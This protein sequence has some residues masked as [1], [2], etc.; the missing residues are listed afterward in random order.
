MANDY[1]QTVAEV[2][3]AQLQA[4]TAPWVRPW[5]AGER[6]MPYN[7]TTGNA[8]HGMNAVWLMA[9]GEARGYPG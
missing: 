9:A 3:I 4:G 8:Y 2:L 6:F 5:T 7:P 1:V